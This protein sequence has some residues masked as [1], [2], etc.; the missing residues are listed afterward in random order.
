MRHT[1]EGIE[2]KRNT[3]TNA[4]NHTKLLHS[5]FREQALV[6]ACLRARIR[7]LQLYNLI[8]FGRHNCCI[9]DRMRA[10]GVGK[11]DWWSSTIIKRAYK[12]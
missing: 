4:E 9:N 8:G 3:S 11:Q 5:L 7:A 2:N 12:F 10:Y 1:P 6:Q